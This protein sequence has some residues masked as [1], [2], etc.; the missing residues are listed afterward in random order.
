[1]ARRSSR[2]H[3]G[4]EE[5]NSVHPL[6]FCRILSLTSFGGVDVLSTTRSGCGVGLMHLALC[7]SL[8]QSYLFKI[9]VRKTAETSIMCEREWEKK[10]NQNNGLPRLWANC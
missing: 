5:S 4:D 6:T 9:V 2:E 3:E 8:E 10:R 7:E 1:M